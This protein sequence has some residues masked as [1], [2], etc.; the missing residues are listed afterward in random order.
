[1]ELAGLVKELAENCVLKAH[2]DNR[3]ALALSPTQEHLLLN[4]NQRDR[5]EQAIQTHFGQNVKLVI[6]LEDSTNET[7]SETNARVKREKQKAAENSLKNDP[8]VKSLMDTF[9]ASIDQ[10]SIQPQ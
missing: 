5:F 1:M 9:D 6:L 2:V 7:P 10:D 3:I 4:Q 8:T